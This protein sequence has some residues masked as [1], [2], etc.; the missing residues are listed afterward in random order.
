[1]DGRLPPR[2]EN[3]A[4]PKKSNILKSLDRLRSRAEANLRGRRK[5]PR[6]KA[7]VQNP[8]ADAVRVLHELEV[9][10][11]ELEMQNAELQE[12]RDRMEAVLEKYTDL[13]DFAPVGY[14]STDERGRILEVNLT[15]AALLG[16]ERSQLINRDLLQFVIPA[17][18]P[19]FSAFLERVCAGTGKQV[20]EASLLKKNAAT[21][22][23]SFHGISAVSLTDPG[24]LCRVAVS[25]I[26]SLKQAEQSQRRVE[27][28]AA[29]NE[30]LKREIVRR[31]AVQEALKESEHHSRLLLKQSRQMQDQLRLLSRQ[32]LSA[33]EEERKKISRELHD[34]IAQTL[35]GINVR[36]ATLKTDA[37]VNTK[38]LQ[39]NINRTQQLVQE[40]VDIVHRFARE[41]RPTVLDDVGLIPALHTFMKGFREETGIRV[42]LSAP[43]AVEQ[44]RGDERTVLYR[45]AQEALTN[46][47][48]HA[49]ASQA[50]V[51]IQKLDDVLC[52][53]VKD[54]GKGFAIEDKSQAKKRKRL[55]LLGMRERLEM[56]GGK[57]AV[58]STPGKG[59]TVVAQIPLIGGLSRGGGKKAHSSRPP[60]LNFY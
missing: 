36:L 48:R 50:D 12:A 24:K 44:I 30:E 9:H 3:P 20:C 54:D 49:Q 34:V 55:G 15:G 14:F 2:P 22:W 33:Q 43:A 39:R 26:T 53:T 18:Q 6:S 23:A 13:Y 45:I 52:M 38:H 28:L 35:A 10:Q 7:G 5:D 8:E 40:S 60:T 51:N 29:A 25:D 59:T 58:K 46:V 11:I 41:L 4:M 16:V 1:M 32:V 56:V 57:F 42:S 47:A 17:S 37:T 19:V 21:F 27:T 31:Q